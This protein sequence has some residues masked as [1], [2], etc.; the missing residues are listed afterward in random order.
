MR[1]GRRVRRAARA[2]LGRCRAGAPRVRRAAGEVSG[3]LQLLI[4]YL[5]SV[6]TSCRGAP[7]EVS[8]HTSCVSCPKEET[9]G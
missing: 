4:L 5:T 2:R 6:G 9:G 7:K 8:A 1:T 3:V